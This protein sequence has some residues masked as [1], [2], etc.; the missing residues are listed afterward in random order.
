MHAAVGSVGLP[1][2]QARALVGREAVAW[3][4]AVDALG[5]SRLAL[6]GL[7]AVFA[8]A[9]LAL[10]LGQG[11]VSDEGLL[12]HVFAR[13]L[14]LEPLAALFFQKIKPTV[15]VLYAVPSLG[16]AQ[17][18]LVAHV[19]VAAL[20]A[21]MLA[22]V[23]RRL[24][25]RWPN[26]P[27]LLLLASPLYLFGAAAGVS[28]TDGVALSI[29]VL[30][31]TVARGWHWAAGLVLGSLPWVRSELAP[32]AAV[33]W[34]YMAL[35]ER[36]RG[37]ALGALVIPLAY[38]MGGAVYHRDLLWLLHYAPTMAFPHPSNLVRSGSGGLHTLLWV[39]LLVTPAVG[40]AA[41][42]PWRRLS[43]LERALALGAALTLL[44]VSLLPLWGLFNFDSSARYSMQP[45]PVLALLAARALEPLADG[46]HAA[47]GFAALP[48]LLLAALSVS[49]GV[50]P[51]LGVLL[52]VA[53]A[54]LAASAWRGAAPAAVVALAAI[55]GLG[56]AL[57]RKELATPAYYAAALDWLEANAADVRATTLYTS[58]AVLPYGI[59][60]R[61]ALDGTAVRFL[62]APDMGWE[63]EMLSNPHNGQRAALA[64]A[65]AQE[66]Y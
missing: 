53:Y 55:A 7:T 38:A 66:L 21:P 10:V 47:W 5:S 26:L 6:G 20:A 60:R 27:A 36:N 13:W 50:P 23:A 1:P 48:L 15:C 65:A 17:S 51:A 59:A 9:G 37:V 11:I 42:A 14:T 46:P 16:G 18:T 29:L 25:L 33:L 44:L 32:L 24:G 63:L 39:L 43:P 49:A 2:A 4:R 35:I 58:S 64:R 57:P 62:V 40:V 3:R 52:I 22:T 54:A 41:L 45:L 34:L 19:L 28:N 31:L 30:Y 12:T 8:A 61:A 56:L